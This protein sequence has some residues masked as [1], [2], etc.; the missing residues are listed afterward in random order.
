M[1]LLGAIAILTMVCIA[2]EVCYRLE[3]KNYKKQL[4]NRSGKVQNDE[5]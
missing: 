2:A 1:Y 3:I 5:N 4:E